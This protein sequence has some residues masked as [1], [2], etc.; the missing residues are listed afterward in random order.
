[1]R[2]ILCQNTDL[3]SA[4]YS[5]WFETDGLLEPII[6]SIITL[7]LHACK[8]CLVSIK[9]ILIAMN[10]TGYFVKMVKVKIDSLIA[11]FDR[12]FHSFD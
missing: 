11:S 4:L 9:G 8:K 1:M 12:L 7:I 3:K 2:V 5:Q 6:E 10:S